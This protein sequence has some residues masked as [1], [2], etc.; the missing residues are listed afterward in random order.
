[1]LSA[2]KKGG[3]K[4]PREN[5]VDG[6]TKAGRLAKAEAA[7]AEAAKAE[8]AQAEAAQAEAVQARAAAAVVPNV[9]K[10]WR[11]RCIRSRSRHIA[12]ARAHAGF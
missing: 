12:L 6:R 10:P 11:Y 7:K 2:A 5:F 9:P 1:M 3:I 8:A 4:A